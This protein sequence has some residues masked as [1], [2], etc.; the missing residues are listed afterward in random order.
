MR[1]PICFRSSDAVCRSC[2]EGPAGGF[3]CTKMSGQMHGRGVNRR[4]ALESGV[5]RLAFATASTVLRASA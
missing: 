4:I 2:P 1:E 5:R 3:L